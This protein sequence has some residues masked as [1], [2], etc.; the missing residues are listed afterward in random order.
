MLPG[1]AAKT[2]P[3]HSGAKVGLKERVTGGLQAIEAKTPSMVSF[4]LELAQIETTEWSL[5][6]K[7]KILTP[8]LLK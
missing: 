3:T 1:G 8:L 6:S 5:H 2:L 4:K 7:F